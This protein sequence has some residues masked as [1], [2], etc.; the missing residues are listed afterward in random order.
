MKKKLLSMRFVLTM[1]AMLLCT[2][3]L[4]AD[5]NVL[6]FSYDRSS[7]TAGLVAN[8][9]IGDVVIPEKVIIKGEKYTVTGV[10]RGAFDRCARVTSITLPAS[11]KYFYASLSDCIFEDCF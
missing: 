1:L 9:Y 6:L 4:M 10:E 11:I 8:S 3:N 2:S 7:H 5:D